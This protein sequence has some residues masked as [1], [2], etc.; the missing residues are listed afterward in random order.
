MSGPADQHSVLPPEDLPDALPERSGEW[1][2]ILALVAVLLVLLAL[3]ATPAL[4][5]G[6]T[7][8]VATSILPAYEA[9]RD[10]AYVTERRLAESR[11]VAFDD[12]PRH[13]ADLLADNAAE[14]S[15][16]AAMTRLAPHL[17][18]AF[19]LHVDTLQ[20]LVAR[21]DSLDNALIEAGTDRIEA[22]P[23]FDALNAAM[24]RQV[25]RLRHV[26]SDAAREIMD[27]NA[28][29]AARQRRVAVMLG[30]IAAAAALVLGWF[31]LQQHRLSHTAQYA[32]ALAERQRAKIE[33]LSES[34]ERLMR[35]FT[36][37]MKNPLGAASGYLQ[38]LADGIF[39]RMTEEQKRSVMRASGSIESAIHLADDLLE[40]ARVESGNLEI[41]QKRTDLSRLVRDVAEEY[42]AQAEVKGLAFD[43]VVPG[44]GPSVIT[45]RRRVGQVLGNL[46]SNA[47]KYTRKGAIEIRVDGAAVDATRTPRAAVSV[48]DTGPGIPKEMQDRLFDE[49]VRLDPHSD[50]GA[51]IGLTIA[52]SI[53]HAL[54]GEIT[55]RSDEGEGSVFTLWL[56]LEQQGVSESSA[57]S[58][59]QVRPDADVHFFQHRERGGRGERGG[60]ARRGYRP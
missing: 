59:T 39:G 12:D 3:A 4:M 11:G 23:R 60:G 44:T 19:A 24:L 25:Q 14:D 10:F 2:P 36:H 48:E 8:R 43:V 5:L 21:R 51:G 58:A 16:L 50:K 7:T 49:F 54:D 57:P 47:V 53:A 41:R 28:E 20:Q 35:G 34:R 40:L 22:L 9:V 32:L 37:D 1:L 55:L 26:F 27:A 29:W 15:A 42:R 18:P 46:I 30:V 56:P 6:R 31:G 13:H 38:L 17:G 45:D 33:R 52:R